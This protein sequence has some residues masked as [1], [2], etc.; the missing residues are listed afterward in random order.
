MASARKFFR[1]FKSFNEYHKILQLLKA[2][3]DQFKLAI[4][5]LARV[6]FLVYWFFDNLAILS[7]VKFLDFDVKRMTKL[8]SIAWLFALVMG[9]IS[10]AV[11]MSEVVAAETKLQ[12]ESKNDSDYKSKV[13]AIN[14]KKFNAILDL[15]KNAGDMITAS[16]GAEVPQNLLGRQWN[17]G[18]IGAGGLTSAVITCYKLYPAA[19]K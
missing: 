18:Q 8:G 2:G 17:E 10:A 5:V 3:G 13:A 19:K 9:Q 7:K 4:N 12:G 1:L 11:A 15:I 6:G 16:H 14:N